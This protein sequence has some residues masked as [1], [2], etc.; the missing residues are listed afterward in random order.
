MSTILVADASAT[1]A[2]AL[3]EEPIVH[4]I[5]PMLPGATLV[6][7]GLWRLEVVN[8]VL[9]HERRRKISSEQGAR[10]ILAL[11]S[12]RVEIDAVAP[13]ETLSHLAAAARPHQLT[14][15][16]AAYLLVALKRNLPLLTTDNNLQDA[17]RRLGVPLLLDRNTPPA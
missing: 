10:T 13:H 2:W 1:M 12:L 3:H 16:D 4:S 5:R 15:Y 17:A 6:V 11:E 9:I 7:P 8:A 14:A